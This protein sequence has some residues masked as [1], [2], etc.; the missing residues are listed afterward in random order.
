MYASAQSLRPL[1]GQGIKS[2]CENSQENCGALKAVSKHSVIVLSKF[3]HT[4]SRA[5]AKDEP[6]CFRKRRAKSPSEPRWQSSITRNTVCVGLMR[7]ENLKCP[8]CAPRKRAHGLIRSN[9]LNNVLIALHITE[10]L[11]MRDDQAHHFNFR[12]H[13]LFHIQ[14]SLPII[15]S[16]FLVNTQILLCTLIATWRPDR[17]WPVYTFKSKRVVIKIPLL[18]NEHPVRFLQPDQAKMI[19]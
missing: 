12:Q 1:K 11:A 7:Y 15:N 5:S 2:K 6:R 9:K 3:H 4:F 13:S 8:L 14:I 17:R 19:K 18:A 10:H 16:L